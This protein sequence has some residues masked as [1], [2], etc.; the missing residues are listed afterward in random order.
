MKK[1]ILALVLCVALAAVA[2]VGGTLAYFTDTDDKTNTFTMGKV[3][4]TL[5]EPNYKPDSDEKLK[6]FPG[7]SYAK[8][9]TITVA[10][11][12]EECW[13]VATVTISNFADLKKLYE[14]DT[15]GVK[16]DWG[17]SLA[18][19]GK[20][21]SGGLA[22]YSAVPKTENDTAGTMLSDGDGKEVAFL[23]YENSETDDT[24]TYTFYFKNP[25]KAGDTET[26]FTT[27]KIPSIIDNGDIS[28]D[29]T[30]TVE[31]Y[32]IQK[33]GFNDVYAAYTAYKTQN[34]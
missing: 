14:K 6:V 20:M 29:L 25:H 16:Q 27:V 17:L 9:P 23:T 34:G 2:I 3:D 31:A 28:E 7:E 19:N 18:G 5:T 22:G 10:S 26:L 32:A 11:D 24:I 1:K 13:L 4:I 12:S 30:I 15:T 21:V 8:D 33:T